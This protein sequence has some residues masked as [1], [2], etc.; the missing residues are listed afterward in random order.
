VDPAWRV[1]RIS[2]GQSPGNQSFSR[3]QTLVIPQQASSVERL[4]GHLELT[5]T[6]VGG[7]TVLSHARV[8]AP[9][10]IV[11]PFALEDGRA[12]VQMMTLGPGMCGGDRYTIDVTVE[13]GARAVVMAQ[14]ASRILAMAEGVRATQTVRLR[15][16]AGG[17]LEYYP[18]LT[19][20]FPRSSLEQRVEV[21]ADEGARVG[22]LESWAMGRRGRG[23]YLQFTRI[24]SRTTFE[25]DG[26]AT[27]T[28]VVHLE[29]AAAHLA[30]S[31]VLDGYGYLAS[32][33]WCG[34]T[35]SAPVP[36]P[37]PDSVLLAVGQAKPDQ[38]YLRALAADGYALGE[39]LQGALAQIHAGWR[40]APIPL[41]RFT[42]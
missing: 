24:C 36:V 25:V 4:G 28:D 6:A 26:V 34:V 40:Q 16:Q 42:S 2:G 17:Q 21:R 29:P 41:H 35:L 3:S 11:R 19:I 37:V 23:E 30:G 13:S 38:V 10:K 18:G 5:F 31:G 22:V 39:R 12:L 27:S 32:G 20:P 8:A 15:V 14:S 7:R 9:L 1:V 33:Y